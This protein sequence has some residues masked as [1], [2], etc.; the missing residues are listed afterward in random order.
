MRFL[1]LFSGIEAASVAFLPLGW[2]CVGF[3]EI[4][5][6]CCEVLKYHYPAVK[7]LGDITKITKKQI[8]ALGRIDVVIY[9]FPCQDLSVAGQRKGLKHED[10]TNTRSGLF[11]SAA[12]I[13]DWSKARWSIAENVPGLF[14][15]HAGRDFASV[16]GELAGIEIG[17][18]RNGWR[19]SGVALGKKG[20]VEWSV[21]DAQFFGLA[22]RRKRV[23]IVRDTGNW[24]DRPP[25]F[26]IAKSL[27]GNPP[28]RG[29][30][31]KDFTHSIAPSIVASGWGFERAGETRGQ[32]PVVAE[33][34]G[35]ITKNY[36]TH[37]GRTAG[38]NGGVAEG[39]LIPEVSPV[40]TSKMQGSSG[41]A[42]VN[43]TAHLLPV[44]YTPDCAPSRTARDCKGERMDV[45][46]PSLVVQPIPIHD[47]ATRHKG[48]GD[49][50]NDDGASNGMGIGKEG[51]PMPTLDRASRHAVGLTVCSE[52][53]TLNDYGQ[54]T[55]T[56]TVKTLR[57][58]R[59]EIG[60]EAFSEW[61]L[62][63]L[64]S[65]FPQEVL[66]HAVHGLGIQSQT[67]ETSGKFKLVSYAL[68]FKEN[69]SERLVREM[70][71]SQR[72]RRASFRWKP[73][74][75]RAIQLAA[76]LQKLSHPGASGE[77][78]LRDLWQASQGFGVLRNTLPTVQEVGRPTHGE[79]QPVRSG[80]EGQRTEPS[81]TTLQSSQ[82]WE[83][84]SRARVLFDARNAKSSGKTQ[85]AVRRL[86]PIECEFLQGF[87]RNYTD[88]PF[89]GKPA[90]DGHKYRSLGNS[91]AVPCIRWLGQRIEMI[92][93]L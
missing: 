38:N 27:C 93:K 65:F 85:M 71:E 51:D 49:T 10:G 63:V 24:N 64:A 12:R 86:C 42:P 77:K 41:W 91:M 70:R 76:Y 87:P 22:Q 36:A 8:E 37:H 46:E 29:E 60:E 53:D 28:T 90:T 39:Q 47:K 1:S 78:I 79:G 11:Y 88:I 13:V 80:S 19:N 9:G 26:L 81:A 14:S 33:I 48:G 75:H 30:K 16:V 23:F 18:P 61:G 2:E 55:E 20:L 25:F 17:V 34:C 57:S 72:K 59:E 69:G 66:Q 40:L 7:N 15:V 83:A 54:E 52:P 3:S 44:G 31:G 32:D 74:E 73:H 89:R 5:P 35:T 67:S 58:L 62:G 82:V 4:E 21:L 6:F 68:S 84:V 92:D 56:D 50:R 43:E 45:A